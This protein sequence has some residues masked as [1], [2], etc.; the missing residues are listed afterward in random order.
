M[1]TGPPP[2]FHGTRDTLPS[3]TSCRVRTATCHTAPAY[4]SFCAFTG[5]AV[6]V[7]SSL[8]LTYL[9]SFTDGTVEGSGTVN[10][11]VSSRLDRSNLWEW[12]TGKD[13]G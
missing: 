9:Y 3:K 10:C 6:A 13:S 1:L 4:L 2:K 8:A 11:S 5:S 7:I 12:V